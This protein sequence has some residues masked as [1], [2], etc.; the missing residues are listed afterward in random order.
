MEIALFTL[1]KNGER[2]RKRIS[3]SRCVE[4]LYP[5]KKS[6]W[7]QPTLGIESSKQ[8][9][10]AVRGAILNIALRKLLNPNITE[11]GAEF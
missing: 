4:R 9:K 11:M 5:Q 2:E 10:R 8:I 3:S 7:T 1:D 6:P